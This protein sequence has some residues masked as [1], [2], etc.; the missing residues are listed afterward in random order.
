M[1]DRHSRAGYPDSPIYIRSDQNGRGR[2]FFFC[3]ADSNDSQ[4]DSRSLEPSCFFSPQFYVPFTI[5]SIDT[6]MS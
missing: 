1:L 2:L 3:P 5:F 6:F 4:I